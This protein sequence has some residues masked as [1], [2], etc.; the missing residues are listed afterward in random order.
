MVSLFFKTS[1]LEN[2]YTL[3]LHFL[4]FLTSNQLTNLAYIASEILFL[5]IFSTLSPW[6]CFVSAFCASALLS[7][8]Y[9]H[10]YNPCPVTLLLD[11]LQG[12]LFQW[13]KHRFL[14][15]KAPHNRLQSFLS[16]S[17]VTTI[18]DLYPSSEQKELLS[19]CVRF[20]WPSLLKH[21]SLFAFHQILS[22]LQFLSAL[23]SQMEHVQACSVG[24]HPP[25]P[26]TVLFRKMWITSWHLRI[27]RF[28]VN[29]H[30]GLFLKNQKIWESHSLM[31]AM[32]GAG[33]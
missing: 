29:L 6:H 17:P 30:W 24:L 10:V 22:E 11:N 7:I 3:I 20:I 13:I 21:T 31:T 16:I 9:S 19:A 18:D 1:R 14:T 25:P 32:R 27:R 26:L 15:S 33:G 4:L 2:K 8:L 28:H 23:S 12:G 5:W